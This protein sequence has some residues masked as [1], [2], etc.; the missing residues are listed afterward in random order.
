MYEKDRTMRTLVAPLFAAVLGVQFFLAVEGKGPAK[1]CALSRNFNGSSLESYGKSSP[2]QRLD[3]TYEVKT[4][5][6]EN[7]PGLTMGAPNNAYIYYPSNAAENETFPF[8]S[9][10]HGTGV[11]GWLPP[12]NVAYRSLLE[13]VASQGF[14]IMAPTTCP[15]VECF[16]YYKDQL[17]T[18]DAAYKHGSDLH[19]ALA[20]ANFAQGVGVFGHSMG[21]MA[22]VGSASAPA[23]YNIKAAVAL[24]TCWEIGL[25]GK[26]VNAPIMFTAGSADVVCEDGCAYEIYEEV[27]AVPK[28][29]FDVAGAGHMEPCDTGKRSEIEAIALFFL[30]KLK[31]KECEKVDSSAICNQVT[32][33]RSMYLCESE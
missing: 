8:L 21:G 13:L 22:T 1:I 10:A 12:L 4:D 31:G 15:S 11:G 16:T 19:P 18:I 28:I 2:F 30:C 17:A 5:L 27:A 20:K 9:F 32:A 3:T 33:G 6:I 7:V 24:H 29:F 14:I 25:S 26:N 23:A